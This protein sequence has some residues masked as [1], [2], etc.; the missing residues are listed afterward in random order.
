M[1]HKRQTMLIGKGNLHKKSVA[2]DNKL[3]PYTVSNRQVDG[4]SFLTEKLH[5][6]ENVDGIVGYKFLSSNTSR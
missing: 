2:T 5:Q 4:R 3:P 1:H 6:I